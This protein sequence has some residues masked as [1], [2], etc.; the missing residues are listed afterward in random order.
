MADFKILGLPGAGKTTELEPTIDSLLQD[1]TAD[2]I[3]DFC[4]CTF[5]KEMAGELKTRLKTKH[6]CATEDLFNVGTIHAICR[7][8]L[9][10][11]P[12]QIITDDDLK[13]FSKS[14]GWGYVPSKDNDY[15]DPVDTGKI[16]TGNVL[17]NLYGWLQN[18][19][20]TVRDIDEYPNYWRL[21]TDE[22]TAEEFINE[23]EQFKH[24]NEKYDFNDM[25]N[26]VLE[27]KALPYTSVLIIDEFQDLFPKLYEVFKQWHREADH[28]Y[29]AGDPYQCIYPFWGATPEYFNDFSGTLKVL[30][31]SWRFG[32][33][34][35]NFAK[36]ILETAGYYDIPEIIPAAESNE[37]RYL[38]QDEYLE[39]ALPQ[40]TSSTFHLVR[41][42]YMAH[43]IAQHLIEAGIPFRGD[44]GWLDWQILAYNG[45]LV[46][47]QK[48]YVNKLL[49][50]TL[51]NIHPDEFFNDKKENIKKA[52]EENRK[53]AYTL[54][55][56]KKFLS[57]LSRYST[58]NFLSS[59]TTEH[60]LEYAEISES[61]KN[62]IRNAL[63][64]RKQLIGEITVYLG[65][66]HS[67]KGWESDNVFVW[68]ATNKRID[69]NC[70]DAEQGK[71]EARVWFVA[72]SRA[73]RNLFWVDAGTRYRYGG[74]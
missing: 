48:G 40:F 20:K 8:I 33:T 3:T 37:I 46:L 61:A 69:R 22:N 59:L 12:K 60:A 36:E 66:I 43:R 50:Q 42:H 1:G 70:F 13:Q 10:I 74:V 71:D 17:F 6:E 21:K 68:N 41:C 38:S 58:D 27:A 19:G 65:T 63:E 11:N 24:K 5:R 31:K 32:P 2:S 14:T 49:L 67:V 73:K 28:T 45:L 35:W 29:I 64:K 30:N 4:V 51:I 25:L 26:T 34:V 23:Y 44:N 72:A 15:I 47:W 7:R 9:D 55:E 39:T 52:I 57:P 62:K 56:I 18:T 16:E 54:K 53:P